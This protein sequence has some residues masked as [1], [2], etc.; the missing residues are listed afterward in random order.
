MTR[1]ITIVSRDGHEFD[2]ACE[3]DAKNAR[4]G[5]V[6]L[7]EIFGLNSHIRSLAARFA[8]AGFFVAQQNAKASAIARRCQHVAAI[9]VYYTRQELRSFHDCH[10]HRSKY[11]GD[12]NLS[13]P[14]NRC[15]SNP[16]ND[17]CR[18]GSDGFRETKHH[19]LDQQQVSLLLEIT[20]HI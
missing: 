8:D 1:I 14:A 6:V 20:V 5:V 9:F 17:N 3:G 7:Q 13:H 15:L 10:S 16:P 12:Q 18:L 11:L 2:A 4:G 19:F